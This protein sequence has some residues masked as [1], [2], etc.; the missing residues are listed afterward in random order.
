MV[1]LK[2]LSWAFVSGIIIGTTTYVETKNIQAALVTA[3]VASTLKTPIY[4]L[5]EMV[6]NRVK[7]KKKETKPD[8][9]P[10]PV[11]CEKCKQAA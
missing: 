6:W 9:V 8:T 5:H 2:T 4:S 7:G 1:F 11:T 3:L 10:M